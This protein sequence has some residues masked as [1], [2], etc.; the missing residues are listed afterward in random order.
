MRSF[1]ENFALN[2]TFLA[3]TMVH[4][5][6]LIDFMGTVKVRAHFSTRSPNSVPVCLHGSHVRSYNRSSVTFSTGFVRKPV[7]TPKIGS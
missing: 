7:K 3:L 2:Q 5:G 6:F 1:V 4:F